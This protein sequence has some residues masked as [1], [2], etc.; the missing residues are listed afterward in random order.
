MIRGQEAAGDT[1]VDPGFM[2]TTAAIATPAFL[3]ALIAA[4]FTSTRHGNHMTVPASVA[5]SVAVAPV[6][7]GVAHG[8]NSIWQ[9]CLRG[10]AGSSWSSAVASPK[11]AQ[12]RS[13]L[14]PSF[15]VLCQMGV[16][17]IVEEEIITCLQASGLDQTTSRSLVLRQEVRGQ[18]AVA[19]GGDGTEAAL[20]GLRTANYVLA[21]HCGWEC[22]F[23]SVARCMCPVWC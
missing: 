4:R 2:A 22:T 12:K 7:I 13:E 23:S 15:I 11:G 3:A 20:L 8:L 19:S 1:T 9:S 17:D 18:V 5:M 21:Y 16:E 10:P 14:S 6:A